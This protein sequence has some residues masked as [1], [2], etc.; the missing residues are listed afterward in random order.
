MRSIINISVPEEIH[1]LVKSEMKKHHFA[2]KSE[3]FRHLLRE[4]MAKKLLAEVTESRKEFRE[5]KGRV[6]KDVKDLWK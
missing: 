6:L 1:K 5:G 3:F 2:S 4:W